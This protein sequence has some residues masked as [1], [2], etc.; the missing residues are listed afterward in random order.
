MLQR[1]RRERWR[2]EQHVDRLFNVAIVVAVFVVVGGIA[3]MLNLQALFGVTASRLV[4][5]Q[6]R[7]ARH[8]ARR[9]AHAGH[10]RRRRRAARL[11]G[12]DV[13]VGGTAVAVLARPSVACLR[14]LDATSHH[15]R[16]VLA[17]PFEQG[18]GR[19]EQQDPRSRRDRQPHQQEYWRQRR[20]LQPCVRDGDEQQ[21]AV[22]RPR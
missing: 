5:H 1:I 4:R 14:D 18:G 7:P 15:H 12:G 2:S 17:P 6:D 10:L 16:Q 9:G 3:A 21:A 19:I 20:P 11:G 13:V 22:R 8:R